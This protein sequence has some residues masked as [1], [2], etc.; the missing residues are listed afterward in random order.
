MN[1]WIAKRGLIVLLVIFLILICGCLIT[2]SDSLPSNRYVALEEKIIDNGIIV[3][4]ENP[5]IG[6]LPAP[7]IFLYN[8][9]L[10]SMF[11]DKSGVFPPYYPTINESLKILLGTYHIV[12]YPVYGRWDLTVHGVYSLPY[13]TDSRITI[14][15]AYENGTVQMRYGNESIYL[16]SGDSWISPV[17][18]IRNETKTGTVMG[19]NYSFTIKYTTTC[20]ITN[21]G[22]YDK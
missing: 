7:Q 11:Y 3:A 10:V 16:K 18:S 14:L 1:T 15:S 9:T 5:I 13:D 20:T 22:I 12:E 19:N 6:D 17:L 21:K 4:G 8:K 2:Y